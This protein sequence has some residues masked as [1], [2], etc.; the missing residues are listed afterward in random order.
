MQDLL[1]LDNE[2][3]M[4]TPSTLGGNWQWRLR[5]FAPLDDALA[6][7]LADMTELYGRCEQTPDEEEKPAEKAEKPAKNKGGKSDKNEKTEKD[8]ADG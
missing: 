6:K 1:E 2:A 5:D 7:K 3:R 8:K 4:N